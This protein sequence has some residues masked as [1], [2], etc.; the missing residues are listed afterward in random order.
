M[1]ATVTLDG[2]NVTGVTLDGVTITRGRSSIYED[3]A[4]GVCVATLL[5][6]DIAPDAWRGRSGYSDVYE[7]YWY[8]ATEAARVGVSMVVETG[9]GSGYVDLYGEKWDGFGTTRFTGTV[10]AV[11]YTPGELT[12]TAV[13]CLEKL[14]RVYVSEARPEETDTVRVSA[15][16]NKAGINPQ[17]L[18]TVDANLTA[19][20]A[21]SD[22]MTVAVA[23]T[24]AADNT[25]AQTYADRENNVVYRR[26]DTPAGKAV[27]LPSDFTLA[28]DLVVTSELGDLYN[29]ERVNYGPVNARKTVEV[30]DAQSIEEFGR[31]EWKRYETQLVNESDAK[32]LG[33]Y[34]LS[35]DK[36][37]GYRVR[38]IYAL[39]L[40]D[41]MTWQVLADSIDLYN[42]VTIPQL[43]DGSPIPSYS[44][45]VLGYTET[46]TA[47]QRTLNL[48]LAPPNYL[49]SEVS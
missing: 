28:S 5:S 22:P 45:V 8:G 23:V 32:A 20:E 14:G 19:L 3:I 38:D 47:I 1:T 42:V 16:L 48:R 13:D 7:D 2:R 12:I 29:V 30:L 15:Y 17:V 31:R 36:N 4:P 46:I 26:R 24:R 49:M 37:P 25:D 33:E 35:N 10:T 27:T 21:L 41:E 9:L 18:G 6:G 39:I 40:D 43:P 34:W 11:D 44:A